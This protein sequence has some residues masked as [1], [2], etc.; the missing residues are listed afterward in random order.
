MTR[1]LMLS[2][3]HGYG[4]AARD[5]RIVEAIRHL[6]PDVEVALASYGSGLEYF[7]NHDVGCDD[8]GFTDA[9]DRS[10]AATWLI[11][12]YLAKT[13]PPDL[14]VSDAVVPALA[15][16]KNILDVE[17]I[18]L[19]DWFYSD[20]GH[21]EVDLL[22]NLAAEIVVLDFVEA[23]R[24]PAA[25][26]VPV[27]FAGPV[28]ADL[29]T[30]GAKGKADGRMVVV[31]LGGRPD[32]AETQAMLDRLEEAWRAGA[33]ADDRMYVLAP[34]REGSTDHTLL[35]TGLTAHPD[36][37]YAAADVVITDAMGF[38]GCDL[39]PHGISVLAMTDP[40][41]TAAF[42]ASFGRRVKFLVDQELLTIAPTTLT[43]TNL[44]A[45]IAETADRPAP[46]PPADRWSPPETLAAHLLE[47]L[48]EVRP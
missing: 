16:C 18:L 5:L 2:G 25:V 27:R 33:G 20:L 30:A 42:P 23:H 11:W 12:R 4:H 31:S 38:T 46:A 48:P 45:L 1:L 26:T 22:F 3:G 35:Y 13:V 41:V 9:N 29:V 6:R 43:G 8:L 36:D 28:A 34:P 47:R 32:R 7:R 10:N 40:A 15:Y 17:S 24:V 14:V 37:Y 19:T 44:W 39:I 21:P